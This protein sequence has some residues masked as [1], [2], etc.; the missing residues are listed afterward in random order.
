MSSVLL[1]F[2]RSSA[3][4]AL[5][6]GTILGGFHGQSHSR[7]AYL[8]SQQLGDRE[9]RNVTGVLLFAVLLTVLIPR[10]AAAQNEP[11]ELLVAIDDGDLARVEALLDA[12]ADPNLVFHD[13]TPLMFCIYG[14]QV[15]I[16]RL[17]VERGANVEQTSETVGPLIT[18]AAQTGNLELL[19]LLLEGGADIDATQRQGQTPLMLAVQNKHPDAVK[20]LLEN[21]ADPD[22]QEE[23]GWT[24]LMF[25]AMRGDL[26]SVNHLIEAGCHV[27][28]KTNEGES[29]LERARKVHEAGLGRGGNYEGVIA[30][31]VAA[32]AGRD[33]P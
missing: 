33:P 5:V 32:G 9:M 12:G 29:P 17:L 20:F 4:S 10:D 3:S 23:N 13:R 1:L 7:H 24:A 16:F 8:C 31:L 25:A 18:L 6:S 2:P 27:N 14:G 22:L 19:G 28:L 21:G 30:A 15:E 11:P 26:A